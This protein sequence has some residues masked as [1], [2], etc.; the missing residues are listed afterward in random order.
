MPI[1]CEIPSLKLAIKI[2]P[3]TRTEEEHFV[4]LTNLNE[5]RRDADLTNESIRKISSPNTISQLNLECS[6]KVILF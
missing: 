2:L 1:K 3:N 4:Y 5:M 6:R